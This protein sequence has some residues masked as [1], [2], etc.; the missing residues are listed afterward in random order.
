MSRLQGGKAS[1]SGASREMLSVLMP[2]YNEGP[3]I[4][5]NI[6]AVDRIFRAMGRPFEIIVVDDGS[7]DWTFEEAC[8]AAKGVRHIIVKRMEVN[9]GKGWALKEAFRLARGEWVVFLDSDLDIDPSQIELFFRVQKKHAADV[10]IGSKRH[11]D[12]KLAYPL[13]RRIV[14]AGYFF[15][16]KLL[17]RLPLRDTQTGLKLFRREVLQ[18]VF[19]R[20]L[21]K[22][23]AFDLE[24]LVLAHHFGFSI[25]EAPVIVN[26]TGKFGHIG[27]RAIFNIW[28][29]TMAVFYRLR[30][31]KTYERRVV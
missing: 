28:W 29:D 3:R 21:V 4:R 14:S 30:I 19:P 1:A 17:F 23:Y 31:K 16:V 15:L 18:S 8:R 25:V 26:Y 20:V 13:K 27:L 7:G 24:L 2:A 6:L 11:P 22:R 5:A 10:V 12:S 9:Q